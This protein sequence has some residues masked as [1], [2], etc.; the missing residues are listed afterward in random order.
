MPLTLHEVQMLEVLWEMADE[1]NIRTRRRY[2]RGDV[3]YK[4]RK[5]IS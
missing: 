4:A 1:G 3:L 2:T 5:L